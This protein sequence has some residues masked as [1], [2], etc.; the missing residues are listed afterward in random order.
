MPLY[1]SI[2]AD[3]GLVVAVEVEHAGDG[4]VEQV[5]VVADHEQRAP[6]G[7]HEVEEPVL[8][9]A[10]EVVGG[11]VEQEHVAA[12][13]QDPGD[14]DAPLLTAGQDADRLVEA[15]GVEAE[16]GGDAADLALG[17]VPAVEPELLLG[18]G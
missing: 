6:V 16:A 2:V 3:A 10:V 17:R 11:L 13:E 4:L 12:G 9:V 5:E 8:G 14:L 18:A 1:S 15:V 7:A